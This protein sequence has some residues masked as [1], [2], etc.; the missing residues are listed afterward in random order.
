MANRLSVAYS[1]P[2]IMLATTNN[3][4]EDLI[5]EGA[6]FFLTG[7]GNISQVLN[8]IELQDT[9][10]FDSVAFDSAMNTALSNIQKAKDTYGQL[11]QKATT[12]P[13]NTTVLNALKSFPYD[14]LRLSEGLNNAIFDEVETYLRAGDI[15]GILKRTYSQLEAIEVLLNNLK[16]TVLSDKSV[17]PTIA[18]RLNDTTTS[19]LLFGSYV[20]R[21][22]AK[23]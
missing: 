21:V 22:F 9:N 5:I 6:G 2:G 13:Y 3:S 4:I 17:D 16:T 11:I 14:D 19:L 7:S 18:M 20:A 10:G 23:F 1:E 8:T 15:N 12:T